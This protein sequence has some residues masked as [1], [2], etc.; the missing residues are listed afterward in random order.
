MKFIAPYN[1]TRNNSTTI[2]RKCKKQRNTENS[3]KKK[4]L[5]ITISLLEVNY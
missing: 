5:F 1:K 2:K 3:L 4:N